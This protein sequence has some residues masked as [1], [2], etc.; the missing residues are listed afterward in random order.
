MLMALQSLL[1][2]GDQRLQAAADSDAAH[3][4]RGAAGDYVRK[5]QVALIRLDDAG[6]EADGR[7]GPRTET[8]VLDY[9][10]KR[11]IVNRTYQSQAD[12]IVGKMT[13]ASLDHEMSALEGSDGA[14]DT[15][16]GPAV[17]DLLAHLD[18]TLLRQGVAFSLPV[19]LAVEKVRGSARAVAELPGRPS[20]Q[21]ASTLQQ[22]LRDVTAVSFSPVRPASGTQLGLIQ[23]AAPV[24]LAVLLLAL[25]AVLALLVVALATPEGRE[26]AGKL[27]ASALDMVDAIVFELL[28]ELEATNKEVR[29]CR[30]EGNKDPRCLEALS[31]YDPKL[32]ELIGRR[33]A[34]QAQARL[35]R[36]TG[37]SL[38]QVL[39]LES[40]IRQVIAL[41]KE[42]R[43]IVREIMNKC[44]CRFLGRFTD[45]EV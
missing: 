39:I 24:A 42:L 12:G 3:I 27:L 38:A 22:S 37:G 13:M 8:A 19:R 9:K 45:P 43:A 25:L 6:I 36:A 31:R 23:A 30:N 15:Q 41:R 16:I 32:T 18:R 17:L 33:D 5:I 1:F 44:G 21:M 26:R 28:T 20:G 2:K 29:H 11:D 10:R 14:T 7:F 35:V 4:T 34:M 40:I